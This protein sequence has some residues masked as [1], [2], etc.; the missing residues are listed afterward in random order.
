MKTSESID[1]V[2]SALHAA[3]NEFVNIAKTKEGYGY[4]YVD[5]A[6]ILEMAKPILHK[7][8]LVI[9]QFPVGSAG[10][11]GI[12]SMLAH[13]S[14]QYIMQ[15]FIMPIPNMKGMNDAQSAGAVITYARRYALSAIIGIAADADTDAS[16]GPADHKP[17][18]AEVDEAINAMILK[19]TDAYHEGLYTDD[20][21]VKVVQSIRKTRPE[22]LASTRVKL[23]E[24]IKKRRKDSYIFDGPN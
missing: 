22:A 18:N 5:Y 6:D 20:E 3:Q 24:G 9:T 11:V 17:S 8:G 13:E 10:N 4:K 1:K 7:H 23:E 12:T 15:D 19:V 21:H 2:A 16:S 14:G